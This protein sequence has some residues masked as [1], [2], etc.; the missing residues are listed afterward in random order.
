MFSL[1]LGLTKSMTGVV[2]I[3][4]KKSDSSAVVLRD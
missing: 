1:L 3:D 2:M 4:V